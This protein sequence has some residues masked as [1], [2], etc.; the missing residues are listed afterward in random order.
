MVYHT[1]P[2]KL[3]FYLNVTLFILINLSLFPFISTRAVKN[4]YVDNSNYTFLPTYL[5]TNSNALNYNDID[6]YKRDY[7]KQVTL[8]FHF[9]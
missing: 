7:V 2:I 5:K 1:E 3:S 8:P 6:V 9:T 4:N